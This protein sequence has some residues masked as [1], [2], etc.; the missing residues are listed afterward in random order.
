[1]I[2]ALTGTQR[3]ALGCHF[4]AREYPGDVGG[5]ARWADVEP[6]HLGAA[7]LPHLLELLFRLDALGAGGDAEAHAQRHDRA[8]DGERGLRPLIQLLDENLVDLDL[9]E[10]VAA[11]IAQRRVPGAEV[12]ESEADTDQVQLLQRLGDVLALL[13]QERLGHLELEPLRQ[14]LGSAERGDH[15]L[16]HVAEAELCRREI[17]GDLEALRPFGGL[18]AG[19]P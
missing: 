2:G 8:Q 5:G 3:C 10:V 13:Q 14:E 17:D 6:L 16:P 19:L 15:R 9:V 4:P 1:M 18:H 11:E 7:L 12:V